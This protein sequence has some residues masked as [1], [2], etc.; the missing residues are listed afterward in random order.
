MKRKITYQYLWDGAKT[1][2]IG[3]KR[4]KKTIMGGKP[5]RQL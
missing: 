3:K 5:E 1:F 2:I 4:K